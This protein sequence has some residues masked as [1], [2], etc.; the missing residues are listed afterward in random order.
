[1]NKRAWTRWFPLLA[2]VAAMAGCVTTPK[3]DWA[4]RV[5]HYTFDQAVMELG[6]PDRSAKLSDGNLVAEWQKC[7]QQ[8]II[9]PQPAFGPLGYYCAPFRPAYSVTR[10]PPIYTRLIFGPDGKL[11]QFKELAR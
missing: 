10:F 11:R 8:I 1:M 9:T 3:I 7:P 2:A 4:A 5:G 6:P